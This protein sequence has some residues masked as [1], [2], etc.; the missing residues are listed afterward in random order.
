MS[1]AII[2]FL[3][4]QQYKANSMLLEGQGKRI[5]RKT[6]QERKMLLLVKAE[7][8]QGSLGEHTVCYYYTQLFLGV[9][10]LI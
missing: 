8:H 5:N 6:R 4:L 9:A 7:Q 10:L 3:V 2:F 1:A